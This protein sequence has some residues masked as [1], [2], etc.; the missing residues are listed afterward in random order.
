MLFLSNKV[1]KNTLDD[2]IDSVLDSMSS[3][4]AD[5]EEYMAMANNLETL[6]KAKALDK[7]NPM[8]ASILQAGTNILGILLVIN[9]EKIGVVTSKAFSLISK[10]RI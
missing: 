7:S 2:E 4:A 8:K 5:T 6:Y 9:Y 10:A 1:E 3:C